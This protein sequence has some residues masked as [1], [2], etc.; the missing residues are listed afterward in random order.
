MVYRTLG[1]CVSAIDLSVVLLTV[2]VESVNDVTSNTLTVAEQQIEQIWPIA[3]YF[4]LLMFL[5]AIMLGLSAVLGPKT[6]GRHTHT[7]FE[8][9]IIA[10]DAPKSRFTNHF[11]LY[12]IFFVIFDL[13][14]IF[15][16][17]W[18]I[19]FDE[20]GIAGF[21]EAAIFIA[22]LFVA[23][24]YVWRIGGLQLK[25]KHLPARELLRASAAKTDN[26]NRSAAKGEQ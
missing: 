25:H 12:A 18:V 3:A 26:V 20:V 11:F 21:I 14:T 9:G 19:A 1:G 6:N 15:L 5:L 16:F 4:V 2:A 22:I 23:L 17:A 7:P 8:S 10:V 13:E 24:I